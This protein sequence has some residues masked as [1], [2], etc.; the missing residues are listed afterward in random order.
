MFNNSKDIP[1]I[2]KY[3]THRVLHKISQTST[4]QID[5]SIYHTSKD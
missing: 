2:K 4:Y 5:S 1:E 3:N